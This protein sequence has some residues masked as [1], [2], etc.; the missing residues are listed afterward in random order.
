MEGVLTARGKGTENRGEQ[1]GHKWRS[2][3]PRWGFA[4]LRDYN[5]FADLQHKG[6]DLRLKTISL[7]LNKEFYLVL[8]Y[9]TPKGCKQWATENL[10][11]LYGLS[12]VLGLR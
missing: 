4:S 2:W 1:R 8:F 12:S 7:F 11:L 10:G 6:P 5:S 3:V 9:L